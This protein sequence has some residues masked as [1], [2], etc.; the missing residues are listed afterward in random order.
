MK[1]N[2]AFALFSILVL[3]TG[4]SCGCGDTADTDGETYIRIIGEGGAEDGS[5]SD[6]EACGITGNGD[7]EVEDFSVWYPYWNNDTADAELDR[8]GE[9]LDTICFFA[10]YF[11]KNSKLFIPD[12]MKDKIKEYRSSGYLKEK[13]SYLTIVN[14][15]LLE[16]GSSLKDTD[17]LREVIGKDEL[18]EK[19]ADD[20]IKLTKKMKLDGVEIDYEAIK[21]DAELWGHF[22]EFIKVLSEKASKENLKLRVLFEP[23]APID[24]F[25]WPEYPEY[26]MMCYNL[27]GYGT[28]P[29]PK[30]DLAFINDLYNKM[31]V[32][33][34]S[35]NMAFAT[36]G[37][38]FSSGGAV[39]QLNFKDAVSLRKDHSAISER[40]SGSA[41]LHFEYEDE[42]GQKHEVWY[43]DG[44]TLQTWMK[45]AKDA[46]CNRISV[47]RL[48]GNM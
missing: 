12:N 42:L 45:T 14:D 5:S 37:F 33:N 18:Y 3:V 46:G 29:G 47:W 36:G 4:V 15:K 35:I 19:H 30:A 6:S 21:K 23:S 13:T 22:N 1:K 20:V 11:D 10:A 48:G 28:E 34:G 39:S 43:A 31:S 26:V 27:K 32:L 44:E 2:K 40:D 25:E 38:D 16:E 9:D 24:S 7:I 8:I 17:L 41:A